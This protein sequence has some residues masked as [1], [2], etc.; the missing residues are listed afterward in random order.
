MQKTS[1]SQLSILAFAF[2]DD[3]YS[4]QALTLPI[5]PW[6]KPE[7]SSACQKMEDRMKVRCAG[8]IEVSG[9][10]S[11]TSLLSCI[12]P[13]ADGKVQYLHRTVMDFLEQP[14]NYRSIALHIEKARFDPNVALLQLWLLQLKTM[15]KGFPTRFL[16][17]Y[18][19]DR[20]WSLA[21]KAMHYASNVDLSIESPI[22]LFDQLG[23][24]LKTF[25]GS[26]PDGY[27]EKWSESFLA[28]AVQYNVWL[29]VEKQLETQNLLKQ[30]VTVRTLLA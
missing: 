27:P 9:T 2:T 5:R 10:V 26:Q 4:E 18:E 15:P 17:V 14:Q 30:G 13:K 11:T 24:T 6:K 16:S 7:I 8:L 25:K 22:E 20:L 1:G 29:Y 21:S 19:G 3:S 12:C 23:R 28:V